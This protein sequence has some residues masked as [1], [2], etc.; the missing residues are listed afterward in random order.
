MATWQK[1]L[2]DSDFGTGSG[3]VAEGNHTHAGY[4]TSVNNSDWSG[5]DLSIAN[6]GTG[7]SSASSARTNLGINKSF[8]DGLGVD[9]D[10]L[11]GQQ[12]SY[13]Q[14]A[15]TA[16]TTST[17]FG[18][19]VSGTYNA[20]VV[21][22]DSHTHDGRYYTES[23]S[24]TRYFRRDT[25]NSVDVRLASGHGRGLRFWDSDNYKIWM[26]SATDGTW[27]GRLDS[28][29]D[30]N[31][32]FRMTG[33][34]NRGFVFQNGTTEV[35]Q[36][37]STGQVRTASANIYANGN[38]VWHAGNDGSG[39]GL[40][41]DALDG[42]EAADFIVHGV[43]NT[44][45]AT[46]SLTYSAG[47]TQKLINDNGSSEQNFIEGS[48]QGVQKFYITN[49]GNADFDGDVTASN[50]SGTNT[51][52]VC[53]TNHTSAGYLTSVNNSNWSGTDLSI[54]NGGTGASTAS[55]A[56][57]KSNLDVNQGGWLG[58][59]T[60][61]KILPSDFVQNADST[62]YNYALISAGAQGKVTSSSLEA[63]ASYTIPN[64]FKAT[65]AT[66]YTS[67]NCTFKIWESD[68]DDALYVQRG[69]NGTATS[70]GGT[71]DFPDITETD[72]N[73][74]TVQVLLSSTTQYI[75]GGY[76]TIARV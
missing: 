13:Y 46:T 48:R 58:Y 16:L 74:I 11:D 61:I 37:E 14:P 49:L 24:N 71:I 9:A 72:T 45:T 25:Y 3:Q 50:L 32:Y 52:D 43:N 18:G 29:S 51:G 33:G 31:M 44:A 76:I 12:G 70:L 38:K 34:T 64:G 54:A 42:K 60:R 8:I 27:G 21:S 5:T 66:M 15:S 4:L 6:G 67:S 41:A 22:N 26:S 17:T 40:D 73:Y 23:E 39:S 20:I 35:F 36:I 63:L 62:T 7:A 69:S 57:G 19:D 55:A 59:P 2:T 75:R 30:Y 1:L 68:I 65:S 47:T 56:R 10:T 28:T 53:T